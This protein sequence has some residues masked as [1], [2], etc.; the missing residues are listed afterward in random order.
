MLAIDL[1]VPEL[2]IRHAYDDAVPADDDGA[3]A[4]YDG[5]RAAGPHM[6]LVT[7]DPPLGLL[8]LRGFG[9]HRI[10]PVFASRPYIF[11]AFQW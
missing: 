11:D 4:S 5:R 6:P 10:S 9:H 1:D 3:T 2:A 7:D 8:V